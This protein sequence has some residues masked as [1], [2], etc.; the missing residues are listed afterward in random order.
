LENAPGLFDKVTERCRVVFT[1]QKRLVF[2]Q[3][4]HSAEVGVPQTHCFASMLMCFQDQWSRR[5]WTSYCAAID[6]SQVLQ[7]FVQQTLTTTYMTSNC[8]FN[9]VFGALCCTTGGTMFSEKD[10][11]RATQTLGDHDNGNT[12]SRWDK[13]RFLRHALVIRYL[14]CAS[15]SVQQ[16]VAMAHPS[17]PS[18]KLYEMARSIEANI[19]LRTAEWLKSNKS[20]T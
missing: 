15:N 19:T 17:T 8:H 5:R 9:D 6:V 20:P 13:T 2:T 1:N 12:M 18:S 11:N 4:N 7:V 14:D 10:L 16:T 3:A